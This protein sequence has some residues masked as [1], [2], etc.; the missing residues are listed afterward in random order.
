MIWMYRI[1][2]F[3]LRIAWH[4]AFATTTFILEL[5]DE[6]SVQNLKDK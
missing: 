3:L 6:V 5:V 1:S 2:I 4:R